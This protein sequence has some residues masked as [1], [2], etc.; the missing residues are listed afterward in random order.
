MKL[1][2]V[3]LVGAAG[4]LTSHALRLTSRPIVPHGTFGAINLLFCGSFVCGLV[5]LVG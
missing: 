3:E 1:T 4:R 5:L 2:M